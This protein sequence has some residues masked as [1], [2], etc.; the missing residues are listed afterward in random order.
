MTGL[1]TRQ[2]DAPELVLAN[3]GPLDEIGLVMKM[4]RGEF[5]P[6]SVSNSAPHIDDKA[7]VSRGAC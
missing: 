2:R 7:P 5:K 4:K 6:V 1:E 3:G